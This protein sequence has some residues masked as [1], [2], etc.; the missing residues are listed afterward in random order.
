MGVTVW[1]SPYLTRAETAGAPAFEEVR[2]ATLPVPTFV[3][4]FDSMKAGTL[5]EGRKDRMRPIWTLP[6]HPLQA[7]EPDKGQERRLA[8]K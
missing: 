3:W 5:G 7:D 6:L 1:R 8:H 4:L 2:L